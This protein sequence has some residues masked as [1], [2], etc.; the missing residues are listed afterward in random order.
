VRVSIC[1][2]RLRARA[3]GG[4]SLE[5][6]L[7]ETAGAGTPAQENQCVDQLHKP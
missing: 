1:L 4:S 6:A 2:S 7:N 3:I 5:C